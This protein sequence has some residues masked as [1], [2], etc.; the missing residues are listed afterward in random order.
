MS[1]VFVMSAATPDIGVR[2]NESATSA[3]ITTSADRVTPLAGVW[4]ETKLLPTG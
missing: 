1:A 3:H 2:G 4:I